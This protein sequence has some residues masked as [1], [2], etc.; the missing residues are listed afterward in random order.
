MDQ[1]QGFLKKIFWGVFL[2]VIAAILI[3]IGVLKW[4]FLMIFPLGLLGVGIWITV[5]S[6]SYLERA[7]GIAM[8][9]LGGLWFLSMVIPVSMYVLAGVFLAVVGVLV[10]VGSRK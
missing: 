6:A 4:P 8:A 3:L 10:V 9:L 5:S 7:W 1:N 2:I